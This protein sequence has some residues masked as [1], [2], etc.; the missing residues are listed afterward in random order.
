MIDLNLS[1]RSLP[2]ISRTERNLGT[3]CSMIDPHQD[4]AAN[5]FLQTRI[6]MGSTGTRVDVSGMGD[7]PAQQRGSGRFHSS[8]PERMGDKTF[9]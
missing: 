7:H 1:Q 8:R 3:F 4:D 2:I 9:L 6:K 5:I